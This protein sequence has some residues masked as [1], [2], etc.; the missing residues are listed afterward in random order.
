VPGLVGRLVA[1]PI[2]FDAYARMGLDP[3]A[4]PQPPQTLTATTATLPPPLRHLR[5]DIPK[6]LASTAQAPLKIVFPLDGSRVELG[7]GQTAGEPGLLALKA[8]GGVTP[9]TWLV[10]GVPVRAPP[11]RRETT[12]TPDGAGFVRVSIIDARGA[13]DSVM[14]RLE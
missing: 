6:T 12:W 2:L 9:L 13:T 10:N 5:K 4:V 8:S 7:P 1:A 11:L 14:V 3:E